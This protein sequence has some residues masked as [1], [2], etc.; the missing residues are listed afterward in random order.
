MKHRLL[1]A[2]SVIALSATSFTAIADDTRTHHQE[3]MPTV[4]EKE[5]E[6]TWDN[7]KE[8][9]RDAANATADAIEDTYKQAKQAVQSDADSTTAEVEAMNINNKVTAEMMMGQPVLN[10]TGERVA[11]V[12]DIILDN[13][14]TAEYVILADGDYTGLGKLVAYS[15]DTLG[16]RNADGE[17]MSPLTEEMIAEAQ[18]FSYNPEIWMSGEGQK[19]PMDLYS[20]SEIMDAELSGANGDILASVNDIIMDENI[21]THL[22]LSYDDFY[23]LGGKKVTMPFYEADMNK[24][25]NSEIEFTLSEPETAD[26]KT[27]KNSYTQ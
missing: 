14:G 8:T 17:F 4:S 12:H 18:S 1:T 23:G 3:N 5:L 10:V 11:K 26:F 9:V 27:F 13:A 6:Q 24:N 20:A 22:I 21:A 25:S 7:T 2:V 19:L 16:A 15:F